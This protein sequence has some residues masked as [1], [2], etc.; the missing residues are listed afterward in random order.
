MHA[1]DQSFSPQAFQTQWQRR[2]PVQASS[3]LHLQ[4]QLWAG[5]HGQEQK[6]YHRGGHLCARRMRSLNVLTTQWHTLK[7]GRC[8]DFASPR[9][10]TPP[11]LA[12]MF[13]H[14]PEKATLGDLY[15]DFVL[16]IAYHDIV[17]DPSS[18]TNEEDSALLFLS[19]LHDDGATASQAAQA[20]RW[21]VP[22]ILRTKSHSMLPKEDPLCISHGHYGSFSEDLSHLEPDGARRLTH[23]ASCHTQHP[24][25]PTCRC[26]CH[27]HVSGC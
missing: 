9:Q 3:L 14:T 10:T 25:S 22:A 4:Q 20:A 15:A 23:A 18:G 2:K 16:A 5:R 8:A 26:A 11:L 13:A 19:H 27:E 6:L 24:L 17:Y 21:V 7:V 12:D 1:I